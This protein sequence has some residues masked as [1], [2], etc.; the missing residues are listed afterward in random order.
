MLYSSEKFVS[1]IANTITYMLNSVLTPDPEEEL[2]A[3]DA[4]KRS[5][6]SKDMCKYV[7]HASSEEIK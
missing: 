6:I 2:D 7:T 3:L 4:R 5:A 1:V